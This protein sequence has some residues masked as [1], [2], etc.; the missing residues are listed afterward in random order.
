MKRIMLVSI[1]LIITSSYAAPFSKFFN[2]DRFRTA[3]Q[4]Y[5]CVASKIGFAAIH[6]Y[7]QALSSGLVGPQAVCAAAVRMAS[8]WYAI[9]KASIDALLYR[10][11]DSGTFH[12][13]SQSL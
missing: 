9:N 3:T 5:K 1:F 10:Q 6:S 11:R 13:G 2:Y 4:Y 7:S 12:K 8:D